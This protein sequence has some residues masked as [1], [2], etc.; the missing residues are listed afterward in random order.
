MLCYDVNATY[1][2][3][4]DLPWEERLR[5]IAEA[6]FTAVE[7]LYPQR[8]NLDELATLLARY[9][10]RLVLLNTEPDPEYPRGHLVMPEAEARFWARF[11][12]A[13]ITAKRLGARRIHV[14][15]G[16]RI[17][18]LPREQQVSVAVDRLRRAGA[19]AADEG[20]TLLIEMLNEH[21]TPGDFVTHSADGL[22]IVDAVG[23]PNVRFQHDFYHMQV[24]EGNLIES[25]RAHAAK[26]GHIQVA[27]APG[28]QMPGRG[29]INLLN[30]LRAVE[31]TGYHGYAG[32][33]YWPPPDES[34]PFAWLPVEWRGRTLDE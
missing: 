2:P 23:L 25:F 7:I 14:L 19:R 12:E 27:D 32:L 10:L 5:R 28:R 24:M 33:E 6:G 1:L 11:D 26:V 8:Q 3:A 21:D 30:V 22:E 18:V 4:G 29:E 15:S 9:R 16:K 31:A 20:I 34:D 17:P 13:L